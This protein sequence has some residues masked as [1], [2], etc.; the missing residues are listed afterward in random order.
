MLGS[1]DGW[2]VLDVLCTLGPLDQQIEEEHK[3]AS[4]SVVRAG[5]FRY[6]GEEGRALLSAGALLLGNAGHV[7]SCEHEHG[8]GDRCLSFQ[9]TP[10]RFAGVARDVGT[11]WTRFAVPRLPPC[12]ALAPLLAQAVL[13]EGPRLEEVAL[14]L[15]GA[16]LLEASGVTSHA[17]HSAG[18]ERRVAKLS[19]TMEAQLA[20]P[21]PLADL[22]QQAGLGRFQLLR[23]FKRVTSLT[24]HQWL[25]R[26]RPREAA[27]L[28]GETAA[29]V[30]EI[31][32]DVAS[33]TCPTSPAHFTWSLGSHPG[34]ATVGAGGL[35]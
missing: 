21:H 18:E 30:T 20:E 24:P 3:L 5:V 29:P 15:T 33:A 34:A 1:G 11:R 32:L 25:L 23:A 10:E 6:Q 13:A 27:R 35:F 26:A 8:S 4:V 17:A 28:L 16:A 12:R 31:A 14:E 9:L 19:R 2:R 7:F 22:A